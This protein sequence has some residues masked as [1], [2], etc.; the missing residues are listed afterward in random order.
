[1]RDRTVNGEPHMDDAH[2]EATLNLRCAGEIFMYTIWL[3]SQMSDL[4]I[5][6]KNPGLIP[7][8]VANEARV[9]PELTQ[10]RAK[11]WERD[12]GRIKKEFETEFDDVL[13]SQ[14]RRDLAALPYLRNAIGHAN[15]SLGRP[16]MLYRPAGE[17]KE[18]E[19]MRALGL[20]PAKSKPM[21]MK[22][23]FHKD[24]PYNNAVALIKRLDEVCFERVSQSI[25]V[26]HRRIR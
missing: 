19:V 8:F 14:D 20:G 1:M 10:L 24:G 7:A 21:M 6:K 16:Y 26:P 25:Q 17:K 5:L 18:H 3:Q 11:Y 2:D 4:L 23:E 13:S 15:V 9:P 12:L 22:L